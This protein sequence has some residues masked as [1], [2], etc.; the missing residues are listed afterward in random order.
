MGHDEK[1]EE[2]K[3]SFA[4]TDD[5]GDS[6]VALRPRSPMRRFGVEML[7]Q[8]WQDEKGSSQ[9]FSSGCVP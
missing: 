5:E 6:R 8:G 1:L 9:A 2:A 7:G 3:L 4:N